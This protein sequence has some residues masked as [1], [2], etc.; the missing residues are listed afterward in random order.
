[1]ENLIQVFFNEEMAFTAEFINEV[2][3]VKIITKEFDYLINEL[4][5]DH[6]YGES[7]PECQDTD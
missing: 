4:E 2:I 6:T 1:M 5:I 3:L 7:A